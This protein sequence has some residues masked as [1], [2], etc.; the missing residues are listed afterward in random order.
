[1]ASQRPRSRRTDKYPPGGPAEWLADGHVTCNIQCSGGKCDRRMVDVRLDALPQDLPW[2]TIGSRL[3]CK[4]CGIAGSV[5]IVPTGMTGSPL[6]CRSPGTGE[7]EAL[8]QLRRGSNLNFLFQLSLEIYQLVSSS[9]ARGAQH[10]ND[11]RLIRRV[12][13]FTA[14]PKSSD[15]T[16]HE[17]AIA[18]RAVR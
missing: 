17:P 12:G 8:R 11:Q 16:G 10:P 9:V 15:G 4:E 2:S 7:R 14:S 13:I 6:P 1:M 3:V 5:H 18:V